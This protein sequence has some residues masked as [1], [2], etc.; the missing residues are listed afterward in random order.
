MN[1]NQTVGNSSRELA[2]PEDVA[3]LSWNAHLIARYLTEECSKTP[4]KNGDA[5]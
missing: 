1:E 3:T 5:E 4:G 2:D